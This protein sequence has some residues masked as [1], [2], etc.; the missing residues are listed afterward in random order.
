ML[1]NASSL[2]HLNTFAL[3]VYATDVINADK[4]TDLIAG[5][6]KAK[7]TKQPV[8]LLGEGSN[9]LFLENFLGTILLNRIKGI[10]IKEDSVAWHLHVGAGENWHQLVSHSLKQSMPGLENLALIPGCVGSAP[11]Q[12]IGAYGVEFENFCEYVDLLDLNTG[13]SQRLGAEDCRFGYRDS[14]FKHRYIEGFAIIAVGIKLIKSW[15]PILN[16]GSLSH[17][18]PST[19]TAEDIFNAVCAIRRNKLP[20]PAAIGNAGS[21]FKNPIISNDRVSKILKSFPNI[22]HHQQENSVKLSAG[23]LIDQCHLKGYQIGGAAVHKDHALVLINIGY[24]TS[25]DVFRLARHVRQQVGMKF[26][27]WLEPEVRFIGANGEV[28]AVESL[29]RKMW[30]CFNK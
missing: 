11:I 7:A 27:I 24:A 18:D 30:G 8:F 12:N 21:F 4:V 10:T 16:Y 28:N 15:S 29:T 26:G 23:W 6:Q 17:L 13:E 22:P 3:P 5:W 19:A 20:D 1:G 9:V 14:I 2:K 25:S